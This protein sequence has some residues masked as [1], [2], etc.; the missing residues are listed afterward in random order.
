MDY[1][2]VKLTPTPFAEET[3]DVLAALLAPLGFDS[4]ETENGENACLKAYIP[5][6]QFSGQQLDALLANLPLPDVKVTWESQV[7]EMQD[8]NH[9]WEQSR[10]FESIVVGEECCVHS[11]LTPADQIPPCR[12]DVIIDPRMSFGSGTHETTS[13]LLEEILEIKPAGKVLDM[14]T[15]TGVLGILCA[16]VGAEHVRAIE[17]DDWVA[18]NAVD[19]V[20]YNG[21]AGRM[22]VECGDASLLTEG[23]TYDLVLANINRNVLLQDMER[24]VSVM[25]QGATLLMSGF[26]ETDIPAI[27]ACAEQLGLDYHHHRSRHDWVVIRFNKYY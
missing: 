11:P 5:E 1:I 23:P 12:Y 14:G 16:L 8:W 10:Q 26:Y 17:I 24:Y 15:G 19:N 9:Q 18:A 13:Q 7:I 21:L 3:C 22:K 25:R 27:R 20:L 4:F 2:E 6:K